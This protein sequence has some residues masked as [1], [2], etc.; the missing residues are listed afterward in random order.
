MAIV[1]IL[2]IVIVIFILKES[3]DREKSNAEIIG[4]IFV[5]NRDEDEALNFEIGSGEESLTVQVYRKQG[6]YLL[7]WVGTVGLFDRLHE[8]KFDSNLNV[9]QRVLWLRGEGE[10]FIKDNVVMEADIRHFKRVDADFFV[11]D[12]KR[13]VEWHLC[14]SVETKYLLLSLHPE[15]VSEFE[16]KKHIRSE[17]ESFKT[18]LRLLCE[19]FEKMGGVIEKKE[20]HLNF[21]LT[22]NPAEDEQTVINLCKRFNLDFRSVFFPDYYQSSLEKSLS[23][24]P[25]KPQEF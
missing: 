4:K 23:R 25:A 10:F 15:I 2:L 12:S 17:L 9:H 21:K 16:L 24:I 19:E 3:K 1:V 14:E 8:Y 22:T 7:S 5:K 18:M 20:R 13:M 11:E 6:Q